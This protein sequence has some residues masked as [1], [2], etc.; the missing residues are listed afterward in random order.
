MT[1]CSVIKVEELTEPHALL[2]YSASVL[3]SYHYYFQNHAWNRLSVVIHIYIYYDASFSL[4]KRS[5]K[6]NPLPYV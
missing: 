1:Y 6:D 2:E 5:Q 3:V 4:L